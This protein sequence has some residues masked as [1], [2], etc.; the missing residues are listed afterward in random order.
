MSDDDELWVDSADR[1]VA[2]RALAEH[3]DEAHLTEAE[4]ERRAGLVHGAKNRADLHA[5]FADLPPPHPLLDEPD[6]TD[7]TNGPFVR[8]GAPRFSR[9]QQAPTRSGDLWVVLGSGGL[10]VVGALLAQWWVPAIVLA[11]VVGVVAVFTARR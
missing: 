4:H 11:V 5:L 2:L 7:P 8:G 10:I 6:P 3:H 1:K 9:Y